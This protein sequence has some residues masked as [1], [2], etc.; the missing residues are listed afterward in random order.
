MDKS[1][2]TFEQN[3]SF[4]SAPFRNFKIIFLSV[5]KPPLPL[6][7]V[8]IRSVDTNAVTTLKR[9]EGVEYEN[10]R[11][12]NACVQRNRCFS[13]GASSCIILSL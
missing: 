6:F 11:L 4:L 2:D 5:A 1:V 8:E 9:R 12:K 13:G 3:R 7:N 10:W